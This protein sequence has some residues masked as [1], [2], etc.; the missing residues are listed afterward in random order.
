MISKPKKK[1][2]TKSKRKN[3]SFI[4]MASYFDL[5]PLLDKNVEIFAI[6]DG[7]DFGSQ[8]KFE[9]K[10]KYDRFLR[11]FYIGKLSDE[12]RTHQIYN[13]LKNYFFHLTWVDDIKN[14]KIY[15]TEPFYEIKMNWEKPGGGLQELKDSNKRQ[16][17]KSKVAKKK[18]KKVAKKSTKVTRTK[19]IIREKRPTY[20]RIAGENAA[21][22]LGTGFG[23]AAGHSFGDWLFD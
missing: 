8:K 15:I 6:S 4:G 3:P 13:D 7:K 10:L 2:K 20:R 22:G 18:V 21:G 14:N 12:D 19:R 17:P 11:R 1:V 23:F 5:E 16:N 9:G